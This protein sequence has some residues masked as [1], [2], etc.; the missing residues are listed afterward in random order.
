MR[1]PG[2]NAT[3]LGMGLFWFTPSC[4]IATPQTSLLSLSGISPKELS[5]GDELEIDGSGFPEGKPARVAFRGDLF[6]P[7]NQV[8]RDVEI[9]ARTTTSSARSL[10]V[11]MT[12]ELRGAFTGK[13]EH[14]KHTTFRGNL[15]ISFSP[16]KAGAPPIVGTLADVVLDIEA[17]LVS[18]ALQSQ[19]EQDAEAALRFLGLTLHGTDI[20]QCCFVASADGRT[21]AI[22]ITT[23][24]RLVD[25]DGVTVRSPTDLVPSGHH[26]VARLSYQRGGKGPVITRDLDVQGYRSAAPRELGPALGLVGFFASCLLLAKTRISRPLQWL[27]WWLA[28]RLRD[29]QTTTQ[30]A[31]SPRSLRRGWIAASQAAST[32]TEGWRVLSIVS[33]VAMSALGT[34]AGLRIDW[35]S[36]E[37]DLPLWLVMQSVSVIWSA[38]LARVGDRSHRTLPALSA[39]L[40]TALYQLPLFALTSAVVL[41]TRSVR[42]WDIAQA[43]GASALGAYALTS[44]PLL[45]LTTLCIL[46]LVPDVSAVEHEPESD[47]RWLQRMHR[48]SHVLT[49]TFHLWSAALLI[50]LLAFGGFRVPILDET[51]QATSH[52]WQLLGVALWFLRAALVVLAVVGLRWVTGHLSLRDALPLMVRYGLVLSVLGAVGALGW[53]YA[54]HR[55]ALGW[56]E[57][58]AG[59][60]LFAILAVSLGYVV[61]RAIRLARSHRTELLPNP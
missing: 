51:R 17:P 31:L 37:L 61:E 16:K 1:Q 42:L 34:L 40:M 47:S 14:A 9:V 33:L 58:I 21:R 18:E 36:A 45:L 48:V 39:A 32:N 41:L 24:D 5:G 55:F 29:A 52:A 46:A 44:L 59:W 4:Q 35:A 8:D 22:G 6:R 15:E 38:M 28:V 49:G 13:G 23:G 2:L 19:R 53:S 11:T 25:L 7:G 26:R 3:I 43:Q 30:R 10:A 20:G 27:T 57:S 12:E 60:V 56:L 54:V 50:S